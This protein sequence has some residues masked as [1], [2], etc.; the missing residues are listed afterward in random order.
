MLVERRESGSRCLL[1]FPWEYI[2]P[3][4]LQK[5]DLME[6]KLAILWSY[7]PMS[8]KKPK[9]ARLFRHFLNISTKAFDG[10]V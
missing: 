10:K 9:S 2:G 4:K 7:L 5:G 3:G 8:R 1:P 6:S